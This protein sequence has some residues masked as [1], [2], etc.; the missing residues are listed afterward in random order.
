[1]ISHL[2]KGEGRGQ[3]WN[4]TDDAS[5]KTKTRLEVVSSLEPSVSISAR[6]FGMH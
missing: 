3:L 2:R 4:E 5:K 1:M 6:D